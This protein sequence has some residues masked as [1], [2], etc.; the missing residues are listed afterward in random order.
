MSTTTTSTILTSPSG[1]NVKGG[2]IV[3]DTTKEVNGR[4]YLTSAW[5]LQQNWNFLPGASIGLA[6]DVP[7]SINAVVSATNSATQITFNSSNSRLYFPFGGK[8]RI[9]FWSASNA[10]VSVNNSYE[11]RIC[12][13]AS[14]AWSAAGQ[15]A[16]TYG[17]TTLSNDSSNGGANGL[18]AF[19]QARLAQSN[20]ITT[21][22]ESGINW[23]GIIGP[24]TEVAILVYAGGTAMTFPAVGIYMDVGYDYMLQ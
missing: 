8:V 13:Y 21:G 16:K 19:A 15:G 11:L 23:S 6:Q 1:L 12:T 22:V 5:S 9:N 17:A 7:P 18:A 14:P 4:F 2:P 3:K 20:L 10:Q 24:Q